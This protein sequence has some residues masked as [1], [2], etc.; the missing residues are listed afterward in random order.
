MR[1][2]QVDVYEAFRAIPGILVSA[3]AIIDSRLVA[4]IMDSYK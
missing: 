1:I 2:K 3:V 4:V